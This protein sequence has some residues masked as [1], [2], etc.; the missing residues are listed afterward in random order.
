MDCNLAHIIM[1]LIVPSSVQPI[2][3][4][5]HMY[6]HLLFADK[7]TLIILPIIVCSCDHNFGPIRL[8]S[9]V[10]PKTIYAKAAF[11]IRSISSNKMAATAP[12][13]II[14]P[15]IVLLCK[16]MKCSDTGYLHNIIQ[17]QV[18]SIKKIQ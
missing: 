4:H 17:L 12:I 6:S 11:V 10:K 3:I 8:K 2:T 16:G 7:N 14:L 15:I 5:V 1:I 9:S 13:H 18:K